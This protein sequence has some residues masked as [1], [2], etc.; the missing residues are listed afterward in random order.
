MVALLGLRIYAAP[1]PVR[2]PGTVTTQ[3]AEHLNLIVAQRQRDAHE[4]W[5]A[6]HYMSKGGRGDD[7]PPRSPPPKLWVVRASGNGSRHGDAVFGWAQPDAL[8]PVERYRPTSAHGGPH[9][10]RKGQTTT[11][12]HG[13]AIFT[14]TFSKWATVMRADRLPSFVDLERRM[15]VRRRLPLSPGFC[16]LWLSLIH[17]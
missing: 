4:A 1:D 6:R 7:D 12:Y 15:P 5:H 2:A 8:L 17:I 11:L 3:T 14:H 9:A 10:C 13:L 16:R